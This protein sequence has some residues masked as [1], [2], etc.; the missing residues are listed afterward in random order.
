MAYG[1][2]GQHLQGLPAQILTLASAKLKALLRHKPLA[3]AF[4]GLREPSGRYELLA[5]GLVLFWIFVSFF[6]M[7]ETRRV[8]GS[9]QLYDL[10]FRRKRSPNLNPSGTAT[11]TEKT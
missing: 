4:G 5:H 11:L 7:R 2:R 1:H 10:F 9:N 6:A 8:F 3:E